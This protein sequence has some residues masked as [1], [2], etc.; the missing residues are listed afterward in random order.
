MRPRGPKKYCL[1]L[2]ICIPCSLA[3][4]TTCLA[5]CELISFIQALTVASFITRLSPSWQFHPVEKTQ[6][7]RKEKSLRQPNEPTMKQK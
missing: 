6:H 3:L 5:R 7:M 2:Y 1:Q 4:S